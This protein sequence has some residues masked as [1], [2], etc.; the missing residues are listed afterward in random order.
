MKDNRPVPA[1]D[2]E[3]GFGGREER[4]RGRGRKEDQNRHTD[5]T[6]E[7]REGGPSEF[8]GWFDDLIRLLVGWP[9]ILDY[10]CGIAVIDADSAR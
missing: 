8:G 5:G 9:D 2:A 1:A 4:R 7:C 10:A 6:N 3:N